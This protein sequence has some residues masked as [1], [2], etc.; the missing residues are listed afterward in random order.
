[1]QPQIVNVMGQLSAT[2]QTGLQKTLQTIL[3]R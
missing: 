3:G 2:D 1:M